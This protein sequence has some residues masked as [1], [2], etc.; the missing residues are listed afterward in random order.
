MA[1]EKFKAMDG[2]VVMSECTTNDVEMD[3]LRLSS[4][5]SVGTSVSFDA[6]SDYWAGVIFLLATNERWAT[7]DEEEEE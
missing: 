1:W 4:G 5:T 2:A 3:D 6:A 7:T